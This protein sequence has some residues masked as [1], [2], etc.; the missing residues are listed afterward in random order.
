[1]RY[2]SVKS[3]GCVVLL[4]NKYVVWVYY[5]VI[6]VCVR[7][8]CNAP[9]LAAA[10]AAARLI[11]S[12]SFSLDLCWTLDHHWDR[13]RCMYVCLSRGV[14][15]HFLSF[16]FPFYLIVRVRVVRERWTWCTES[17]HAIH[18]R[19]NYPHPCQC[20][21]RCMHATIIHSSKPI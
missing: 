17:K 5:A 12:F 16:L 9:S 19:S 3:M 10:E 21:A 13:S 8:E 6:C 18:A 20:Q 2:I 15:H 11:E 14:V 4:L 1:M 7:S